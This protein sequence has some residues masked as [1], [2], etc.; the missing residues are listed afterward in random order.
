[1]SP[2]GAILLESTLAPYLPAGVF[3]L[4]IAATGLLML[5]APRLLAPRSPHPLKE[6]TYE[7]GVTPHGTAR[8]QFPVKFYLV[9]ILFVLFDIETVFLIPWAVVFR[10]FGVV[11][12]V[13]MLVF[14][15]ILAVGLL[16]VWRRRGLEWE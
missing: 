10:K 6:S 8:R 5:G 3:L 11:G 4:L 13:E 9:A 15:F 7:C 12:V 14:L 16:Y 2:V 1:V